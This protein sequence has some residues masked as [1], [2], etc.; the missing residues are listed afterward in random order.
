MLFKITTIFATFSKLK[1][2]KK[3]VK[4]MGSLKVTRAKGSGITVSSGSSEAKRSC[5]RRCKAGI[6]LSEGDG[7]ERRGGRKGEGW[8]AINLW[9]QL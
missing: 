1:T 5:W 4:K 3:G 8:R 6:K 7:G 2:Q 9:E